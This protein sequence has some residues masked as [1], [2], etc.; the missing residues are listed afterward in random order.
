MVKPPVA[1]AGV[2]TPVEDNAFYW[3]MRNEFKPIK[4]VPIN[5]RWNSRKTISIIQVAHLYGNRTLKGRKEIEA[6]IKGSY[7]NE[8][9]IPYEKKL[10]LQYEPK[11][12]DQLLY[13]EQ[14]LYQCILERS[15]KARD[16]RKS[17]WAR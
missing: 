4:D 1:F 7:L 8:Y 6:F 14:F 10:K 13:E 11:M 12:F 16:L 17:R 3:W 9:Y 2:N 5:E 15:T